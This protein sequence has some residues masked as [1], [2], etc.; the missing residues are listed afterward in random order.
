MSVADSEKMM[1]AEISLETELRIQ[2]MTTLLFL[3]H[4]LSNGKS[5]ESGLERDPSMNH[6]LFLTKRAIIIVRLHEP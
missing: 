4:E 6:N 5:D 3:I 1:L 2:E